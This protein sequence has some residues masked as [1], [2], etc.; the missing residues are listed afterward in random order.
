MAVR[1]GALLLA[2][3]Y[4]ERF[5]SSKLLAE[6]DSGNTLFTQT[7]DRLKA[8]VPDYIAVTRPELAQQLREIEPGIN[9]CERARQGMGAS[10]AFGIELAAAAQW[11]ATLICLADMPF[12]ES[13]TYA[14]L[15]AA[16]KPDAIVIPCFDGRAG[17]PVSFGSQFYSDLLTLEGDAGGRVILQQHQ[18][19]VVKLAMDSESILADIDTPQDLAALQTHFR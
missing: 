9:V 6:L 19:S 10:L 17:N 4:S 13:A 8:V 5:G 18:P 7:R 16:A 11:D 1:V 3:G 15:A 2:A 14:Q 12:I